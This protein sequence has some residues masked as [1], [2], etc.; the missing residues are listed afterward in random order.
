MTSL[1][2]WVLVLALQ[3]ADGEVALVQVGVMVSEEACNLAGLGM[4]TL[5]VAAGA[6]TEAAWRCERT[7]VG[8]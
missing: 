5:V 1:V 4:T 6:F 2:G 3:G 7:G 8:A